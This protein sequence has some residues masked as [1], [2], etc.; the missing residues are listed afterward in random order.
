LALTKK[1]LNSIEAVKALFRIIADLDRIV[2][3]EMKKFPR[4]S[5]GDLA[6]R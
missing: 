3:D 2:V 1:L 4:L 5:D 6:G